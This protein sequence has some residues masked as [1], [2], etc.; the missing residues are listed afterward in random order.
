[1]FNSK[2]TK[3]ILISANEETQSQ[4]PVVYSKVEQN[5]KLRI[6]QRGTPVPTI[7]Q[8]EQKKLV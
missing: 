1:M 4:M 8:Q 7:S 5:A 3:H 2:Y 6:S